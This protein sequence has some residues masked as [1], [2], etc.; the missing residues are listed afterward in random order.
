MKALAPLPPAC[1]PRIR[2]TLAST[3][4]VVRFPAH[5]WIK[6]LLTPKSDRASVHIQGSSDSERYRCTLDLWQDACG[7][8]VAALEAADWDT[9]GE[10][11]ALKDDL[12]AAWEREGVDVT[13]LQRSVA[14][15]TR[16][17]WAQLVNTIQ[18]L[19]AKAQ[20]MI[21]RVMAELRGSLRQFEFERHV[22]RSYQSLPDEITPSFHDKKY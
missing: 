14:S 16:D 21:Q 5:P 19:D 10:A 22:M 13:A 20:D 8:Q 11:L 1:L 3:S 6:P 9:F 7:R 12:L 4:Y 2:S 18:K 15:S 17:E